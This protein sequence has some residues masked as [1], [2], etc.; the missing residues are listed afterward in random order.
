MED[1]RLP[2]S[3]RVSILTKPKMPIRGEGH[4]WAYK[5][6][7]VPNGG[8]RVAQRSASGCFRPSPGGREGDTAAAKARLVTNICRSW[9]SARHF[10]GG[11]SLFVR[12]CENPT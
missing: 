7:P 6:G 5:I 12:R 11:G 2:G 8:I 1:R 4:A 9:F 10:L 3:S